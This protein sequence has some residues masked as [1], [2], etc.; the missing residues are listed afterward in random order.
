MKLLLLCLAY[1]FRAWRASLA[2]WKEVDEFE[3]R[4]TGALR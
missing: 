3:A 1:P 2:E 4:E